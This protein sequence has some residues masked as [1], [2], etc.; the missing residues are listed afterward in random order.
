MKLPCGCEILFH[1]DLTRTPYIEFCPLHEAA[2]NLLEACERALAYCWKSTND[3]PEKLL[4]Q[5][6]A[7]AERRQP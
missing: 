2:E 6:I 4:E 7:K 5:A 1:D 3:N